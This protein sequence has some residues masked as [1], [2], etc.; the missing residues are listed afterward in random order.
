MAIAREAIGH[1]D[2][3]AHFAMKGPA[4]GRH[5]AR[6]ILTTL[7][8]HD[9]ECCETVRSLQAHFQPEPPLLPFDL[10]FDPEPDA[11]PDAEPADEDEAAEDSEEYDYSDDEQ[12]VGEEGFQ[13]SDD[14]EDGDEDDALE[15][16]SN[17]DENS[18]D[19]STQ[20]DTGVSQLTLDAGNSTIESTASEKRERADS[21]EWEVVGER[22]K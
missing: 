21:D 20:V 4:L 16:A 15:E 2:S 8:V 22:G 13:Y 14:G 5:V 3:I 12:D 10:L 17:D 1:I 11:E 9:R 19:K 7:A 6:D 18:G